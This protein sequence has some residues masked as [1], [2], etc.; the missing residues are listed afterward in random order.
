MIKRKWVL[1]SCQV[2]DPYYLQRQICFFGQIVEHFFSKKTRSKSDELGNKNKDDF[3][4][5][6]A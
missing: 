4:I 2:T 5:L 6:E 3:Y 1:V